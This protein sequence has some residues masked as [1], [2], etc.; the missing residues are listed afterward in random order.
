[1]DAF[2]EI[3]ARHI[4][5]ASLSTERLRVQLE[6][7]VFLDEDFV[8]YVTPTPQEGDSDADDCADSD[9]DTDTDSDSDAGT[10]VV[11]FAGT[12]FAP[13]PSCGQDSDSTE[14][15]DDE[16][17]MSSDYEDYDR[18][19]GEVCGIQLGTGVEGP[20]DS[21]ASSDDEDEESDGEVGEH[22]VTVSGVGGNVPLRRRNFVPEAE[23]RLGGRTHVRPV[24]VAAETFSGIF[25]FVY[26]I[27][28]VILFMYL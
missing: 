6:P 8:L 10:V 9:G 7:A 18:A 5:L 17:A 15:D 21:I 19:D 3:G 26:L 11:N 23:G 4:L 22:M 12:L 20:P 27:T 28:S 13:P 14:T 2:I 24:T 16:D 1:M 25:A